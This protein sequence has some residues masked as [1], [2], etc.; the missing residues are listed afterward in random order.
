MLGCKQSDSAFF[1][2]STANNSRRSG[3]ICPIIKLI[4]DLMGIY[5][6]VKFGTDWSISADARF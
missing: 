4:Q 6:V 5:I 2:N 1:Q 3:L